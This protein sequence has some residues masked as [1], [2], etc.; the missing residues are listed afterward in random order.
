MTIYIIYLQYDYTLHLQD[1][2]ALNNMNAD[3]PYTSTI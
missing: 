2:Y 1:D 3:I